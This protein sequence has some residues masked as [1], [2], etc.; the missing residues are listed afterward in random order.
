[1]HHNHQPAKAGE[2]EGTER[3][4]PVCPCIYAK[5]RQAHSCTYAQA[6][7]GHTNTATQRNPD[8]DNRNIPGTDTHITAHDL[9]G[10]HLHPLTC[11][12]RIAPAYKHMQKHKKHSETH[13]MG[14]S[15][16]RQR[17][18]QTAKDFRLAKTHTH[19]ERKAHSDI[20]AFTWAG[21]AMLRQTQMERHFQIEE[22]AQ[23]PISA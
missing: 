5:Y 6:H 3:E 18:T 23:I 10:I 7:A 17:Q 2:G 20:N 8:V 11:I 22:H 21:T 13:V 19:S 9:R 15:V 16:R 1:M 12:H 14:S 4:P